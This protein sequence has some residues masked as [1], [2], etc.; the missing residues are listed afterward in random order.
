VT[1]IKVSSYI[2]DLD[3]T[4]YT[5]DA[6]DVAN[7]NAIMHAVAK[8]SKVSTAEASMKIDR[9][10]GSYKLH[11]G[12]PSLYAAA[13]NIGV[14]DRLIESYQQRFVEPSQLLRPDPELAKILERLAVGSKLAVLTNTRTS[15]AKKA[16]IA[17]GIPEK[18]FVEIWGGELLSQPKPSCEDILKLC[19]AMGVQPSTAISVGDRWDVD[20]APAIKAG[21]MV[22]EVKDRDDLVSWLKRQLSHA[23]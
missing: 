1:A 4:L 10:L 13:L 21:M 9:A 11:Q 5:T 20:L 2:F 12:R 19:A 15:I 17:L 18:T 23:D 14:P 8:H 22:H 3:G 7:R 16:L 6:M